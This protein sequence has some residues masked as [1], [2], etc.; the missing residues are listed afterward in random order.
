[1]LSP[2]SRLADF[3]SL[4]AMTYLNT[5]AEC[6]PPAAVREA[7]QTYFDHK[8][9]GMSGR[10]FLFAELGHCREQAAGLLKMDTHEVSLC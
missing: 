8:S 6:I 7:L 5:A 3:P 9:I 4:N 10:E 1:M 2:D